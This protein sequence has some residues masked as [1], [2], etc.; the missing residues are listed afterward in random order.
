M[1]KYILDNDLY[2]EEYVAEYTNA[3]YLVNPEYTFEA[4][5]FSGFQPEKR[6]TTRAPG[7]IRWARTASS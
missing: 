5:I 7:G 3:S 2:Q 4:G 1:I 6:P